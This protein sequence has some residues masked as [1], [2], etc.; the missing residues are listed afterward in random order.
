MDINNILHNKIHSYQTKTGQ[1]PTT[2]SMDAKSW[3]NLIYEY[4]SYLF[5]DYFNKERKYAGL[6]VR[7]NK[8]KKKYILVYGK[9]DYKKI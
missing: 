2:I 6:N 8:S 9:D 4:S 1:K 7:I 5:R 3:E